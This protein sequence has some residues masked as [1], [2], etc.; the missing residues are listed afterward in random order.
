MNPEV[1]AMMDEIISLEDELTL[2]LQQLKPLLARKKDL[3][4]RKKQ[5]L[6]DVTAELDEVVTYKNYQFGLVA[7]TVTKYNKNNI[8][9]HL[10]NQQHDEYVRKY[11]TLTSK[12]LFAQVKPRNN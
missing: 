5:L 6:L 1:T 7:G 4:Q 11:S 12:P 3:V 10:N 2:L 8:I 9:E